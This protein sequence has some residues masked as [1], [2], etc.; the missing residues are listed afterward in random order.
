[1]TDATVYDKASDLSPQRIIVRAAPKA[2]RPY[3]TLMRLDRPNGAWLVLSPCWWSITLASGRSWPNVKMLALFALGAFIMRGAGCVINDIVD[4]DIDARVA[5]TANRPIP[6]GQVSVGQAAAF[7]VLLCLL[8]LLILLQF[9]AFA[10]VTGALSLVLVVIYPFMKRYSHWP[11]FFLG[12]AASWGALLG[13]AAVQGQLGWAPAVLYAA[14][15]FWTLGWDTI[16]GHQDKEDDARVGV[17][18]GA[19]RLGDATPLW[20]AFFYTVAVVLMAAAGWLADV[21]LYFYPALLAAA[22]H[23]VWQVATLDIDNPKNCLARFSA[24]RDFG[25]LAF[26]AFSIGQVF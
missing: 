9:N 11:Q 26:L 6:T 13:W 4:R 7:A 12:V 24:N 2:W 18:S 10:V 8:G 21:S 3:L 15:V 23:L 25:F 16:Y 17:K 22:L 1:M 19:L 14:G 20:V 5:R